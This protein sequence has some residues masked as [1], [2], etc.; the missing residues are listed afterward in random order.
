M[1]A[2]IGFS[3]GSMLAKHFGL[4][5]NEALFASIALGAAGAV[6]GIYLAS[7]LKLGASVGS[8]WPV[9]TI[10]VL[11]LIAIAA[12]IFAL[13]G[14]KTKKV[15]FQC[16]PWQAPRGGDNCQLCNDGDLPCTQYKCESLGQS[17]E[18]TNADSDYASCVSV[19]D[20]GRAPEI[21]FSKVLTEVY[22]GNEDT[23]GKSATIGKIGGGCV[24]ANNLITFQLATD[25]QAQCKYSLTAPTGPDYETFDGEFP[26]VEQNYYTRNHTFGVQLPN[27]DS[28][29]E[30]LNISRDEVGTLY[31]DLK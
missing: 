14:T 10:I 26:I 5:K 11:I 1:G 17:C 16:L 19:K 22:T 3:V 20:D 15:T 29:A 24:P 31:G 2:A 7:A 8:F 13:G 12:T 18:Y 28:F 21:S 9:G 25:K 4:T 23:S 30:Y 6:A 27:V